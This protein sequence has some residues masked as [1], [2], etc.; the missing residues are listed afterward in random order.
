MSELIVGIDLGTTNSELAVVKDGALRVVNI[1]GNPIMPSCVG[2]DAAGKLIVGQAAKNQLVAAAESTL[3]SIKRKMGESI[4]VTLGGKEYSP[5]EISSFILRE[6]IL[7][8]ERELGQVI[9]KAVITVP[10]FFNEQQRRATQIAGELAGLEVMRIINEPTAAALAYGAGSTAGETM[11]V[12]DLGGG[13]FDVSVVAVESGVVEVKASHG[14]T[15]LGGDDFDQLLVNHAIQEFKK[16]HN[17][18]LQENAPTLRR[19]KVVMERAKRVL[20]DEPFTVIREEYLDGSHHLEFELQR[21][22]Y[23][24]MIASLLEK[25]LDC[26]HQSL[27]DARLNPSDVHKIM[28]V[29]GATRTPLVH[30]LLHERLGLEPR[31]EINPDLIVAMGA[32]IQAGVMAGE[33]SHSILVDITPHTYSTSALRRDRQDT[34]TPEFMCVP[35]IPRNTPLPAAKSEIFFTVVDEQ[36]R[37]EV[38]VFQGE[39]DEPEENN[40]IG[41]FLVENLGKVPA[42]NPLVIHYDLD[43][44]GLLKVTATE[45][46]TGMAKTVVLDTR[47]AHALDVSEARRNIAALIGNAPGEEPADSGG[48]GEEGEEGEEAEAEDLLGTAKDLRKRAEA[49]LPKNLDAA[50]AQEIRNLVHAAANAIKA[51]DWD[52]LAKNNEALGDLLFYLED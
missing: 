5:E 46:N 29:G 16:R 27:K 37:A 14:D 35:I 13:T 48:D 1:H 50:D 47:G 7:E 17:V 2:L 33:K 49:L 36:D 52:V 19:L 4:K 41:N 42:G 23:E 44:N 15:H 9:R 8:A 12:Y 45:K 3:L 6:L 40:F 28:L 11:L 10:A 30:R 20:S 43:V 38:T 34:F 51:R 25:T 39:S 21:I 31:F 22:E 24:T 32:A 26:V 18:D